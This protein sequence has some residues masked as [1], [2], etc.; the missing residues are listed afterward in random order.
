MLQKIEKFINDLALNLSAIGIIAIIAIIF[1][2]VI[3]RYLFNSGLV[4]VE[5]FSRYIIIWVAFIG[6]SLAVKDNKHVSMDAVFNILP[7]SKKRIACIFIFAV[8]GIVTTGMLAL[9]IMHAF[10]FVKTQQVSIALDWFPMWLV[11]I[12]VPIGGL[13]MT[14][15]YFHLVQK[16]IFGKSYVQNLE[17]GEK[18]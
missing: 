13:F 8:S 16:N 15:F 12:C 4:W 7:A 14:I 2:N 1:V 6:S 18:K 11:V 3:L 5:E 10:S 17:V 9:G